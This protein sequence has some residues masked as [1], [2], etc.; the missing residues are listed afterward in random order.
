MQKAKGT[1]S[2]VDHK[3]PTAV[4]VDSIQV[5]GQA[6]PDHGKYLDIV[7]KRLADLCDVIQDKEI[8][9][10]EPINF[11][12][13]ADAICQ[14]VQ[15]AAYIVRGAIGEIELKFPET[16]PKIDIQVR[17]ATIALP[18]RVWLLVAVPIIYAMA[19]HSWIL[20]HH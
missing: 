12:D 6:A 15:E 14:A 16:A 18:K 11:D 10:Q 19:I 4:S 9:H 7:G 3:S 5:T 20:F 17:D 8:S 13:P 2:C 1:M